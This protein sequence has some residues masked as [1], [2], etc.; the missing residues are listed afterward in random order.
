MTAIIPRCPECGVDL[1]RPDAISLLAKSK[2]WYHVDG[3]GRL[4]EDNHVVSATRST[5]LCTY[6]GRRLNA[7]L[8]QYRVA[9]LQG[10][11]EEKKE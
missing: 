7:Y 3:A 10:A 4:A 5:R 11:E 1:R 6:C 9:L 2:A 8:N